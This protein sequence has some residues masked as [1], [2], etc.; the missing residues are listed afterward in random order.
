MTTT[1]TTTTTATATTTEMTTTAMTTAMD[2]GAVAKG[3]FPRTKCSTLF[4]TSVLH[5][6]S[7]YCTYCKGERERER[8]RERARKKQLLPSLRPRLHPSDRGN[9]PSRKKEEDDSNDIVTRTVLYTFTPQRV[10]ELQKTTPAVIMAHAF[11][12]AVIAA[13]CTMTED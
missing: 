5:H 1:T 12:C 11:F 6:H 9:F 10:T 7:W 2:P 4:L 13:C 3:D 8:E